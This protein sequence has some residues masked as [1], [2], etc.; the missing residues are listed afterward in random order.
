MKSERQSSDRRRSGCVWILALGV[1]AAGAGLPMEFNSGRV[2]AADKMLLVDLEYGRVGERRLLL[3]L[4]LP[5]DRTPAPLIVWVHGGAWRAGSKASPPITALVNRGYAIASLSYRLSPEAPF[6]A[7]AQDITTAIRWLKAH[8]EKYRL[9]PQRVVLCGASAGG[10]LAAV[11]GVNAAV[12][13]FQG[14]E[15]DEIA[16]D[17]AVPTGGVQAVVSFYGASNLQ[18]ILEQS[19]PHGLS[20]RVPALQLLLRG[21]PTEQPELAR[22]ASPVAHVN[23][24]SPPLLLIHGDADPQMPI[25]QSYELQAAYRKFQR[26]VELIVVKDGTHGGPQFFDEKM[27]NRVD[28]FLKKHLQGE[29]LLSK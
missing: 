15:S 16:D 2:W 24:Q 9:D 14:A 11:A 1:W 18:S 28:I 13:E 19:T 22:L 8:A 10:H 27:L 21:Q 29:T 4:Y 6:P 3:D 7:Q 20:V 25:A 12:R 5:P 17:A 26:P 23:A